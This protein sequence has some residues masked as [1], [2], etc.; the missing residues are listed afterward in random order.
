M[1]ILYAADGTQG[2]YHTSRDT[3]L[4][5]DHIWKGTVKAEF[6]LA[7]ADG[8]TETI[9]CKMVVLSTV[10]CTPDI[11]TT[12][13]SAKNWW[14]EITINPGAVETWVS[15]K[16]YLILYWFIDLEYSV[17]TTSYRNHHKRTGMSVTS[18]NGRLPSHPSLRYEV[19][20]YPH[21]HLAT[22]SICLRYLWRL[23]YPSRRNP[24]C[25]YGTQDL[26]RDGKISVSCV[27]KLLK[28]LSPT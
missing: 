9:S 4:S 18:T 13:V 6:E 14:T 15:L 21:K 12:L 10:F 7:F 25:R 2:W 23:R 26:H 5:S 20:G 3:W 16:A 27:R 1:H 28:W 8:W 17:L 19:F 24:F 11:G 22:D